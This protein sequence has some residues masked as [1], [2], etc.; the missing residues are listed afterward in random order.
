MTQAPLVVDAPSALQWDDEADVVVVG[1]GAAGATAAIEARHRGAD[2]LVLDRFQG[3]GASAVSGGVVYAGNTHIQREAGTPDSVDDMLAYL[4]MEVGDGVSPE[5]LRRFCNES[6]GNLLWLE[7]QGARFDS[8]LYTGKI[9]YPPEGTFLYYSGNE[10]M[11]G[12]REKARPAPRGHRTF[13]NGWTGRDLYAA[14]RQSALDNGARLDTHTKA[15][16]LVTD[17]SGRVIGVEVS[18]LVDGDSVRAAHD[19]LYARVSPSKPFNSG[20]AEEAT[21]ACIALE[22]KHGRRRMIRARAGVVLAT[23]GFINN[24]N[25]LEQQ[26]PL[27]ARHYKSITRMGTLGC[28]GSGIALGQSAGGATHMIDRLFIAKSLAPPDDLLGGVLVNTAGKRFINEESYA[29][30]VGEAIG[31]QEEGA[32][33]LIIDGRTFRS[34]ITRTLTAGRNAFLFYS[35]PLLLN[36]LLGGTRRGRTLQALAKRCGIDPHG[37]TETVSRYNRDQT[38][39]TVDAW[40]KSAANRAPIRS[41]ACW[42]INMAVTNK[43]GFTM[44]MSLGG[45]KVDQDSGEV[46]SESGAPIA[47]LYAIGRAATGLCTN[48]NLSGLSLADCVFSGRRAARHVTAQINSRGQATAEML[49]PPPLGA[50]ITKK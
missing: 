37:L 48:N 6:A 13:G 17:T 41:G 46:L 29:G 27:F 7:Q 10:L 15:T 25:M 32:A 19:Q 22:E 11:A 42:A 2:V 21:Q 9:S 47:G 28:D 45:L 34:A 12:Y 43:Y 23:G 44:L 26:G 14:L 30:F 1:F 36:I 18:T 8:T 4:S 49:V 3:G 50:G 35:L 5:A 40:G 24:L 20:P 39:A 31:H 33:W 38:E 16:R